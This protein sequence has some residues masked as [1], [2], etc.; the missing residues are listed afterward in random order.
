MPIMRETISDSGEV[1]TLA[2]TV[3]YGCDPTIMGSPVVNLTEGSRATGMNAA[4]LLFNVSI[5]HACACEDA[6]VKCRTGY[7]AHIALEQDR[8]KCDNYEAMEFPVI[9]ITGI[10]IFV[11]VLMAERRVAETY[12]P[13]ILCESLTR[14]PKFLL[15][16]VAF[17]LNILSPVNLMENRR[18]SVV[19]ACIFGTL[20]ALIFTEIVQ[21]NGA[22]FLRATF[23]LFLLYPL[24]LCRSCHDRLS[25]S[26]LGLVYCIVFTF[27]MWLRLS[28]RWKAQQHD[29]ALYVLIPAVCCNVFIGWFGFRGYQEIRLRYFSG[30]NGGMPVGGING[31][32]DDDFEI[33]RPRALTLSDQG[34][35]RQYDHNELVRELLVPKAQQEQSTDHEGSSK[36]IWVQVVGFFLSYGRDFRKKYSYFR[37]S[38]RML[39]MAAMSWCMLFN[40]MVLLGFLMADFVAWG[41]DQLSGGLCC[42]GKR[43]HH[44]DAYLWTKWTENSTLTTLIDASSSKTYLGSSYDDCGTN[45]Q[46]LTACQITLV[47]AGVVMAIAHAASVLNLVAVYRKHMM[48][49][50]RGDI[51]FIS[52][53]VPGPYVALTDC[54]KYVSYQVIFVICGWVFSTVL[55]GAV[56]LLVAFT[57]ILPA[58]GAYRDHFWPWIWNTYCW[59]EE[60]NEMGP[61]MLTIVLYLIMMVMV[62]YCFMDRS[63]PMALTNRT[64]WDTF[65]LFQ[66]I[67]NFLV[68]FFMFLKR[69]VV[70]VL[71]GAIFISRLDKPLVPRGYEFWDPGFACY[72]GFLLTEMFYS[73][74]VM[75]TFVQILADAHIVLNRKCKDDDDI[76]G[77]SPVRGRSPV[78]RNR[79]LS[80]RAERIGRVAPMAVKRWQLVYTLL[81]NPE[82]VADRRQSQPV[83]QVEVTS[84]G[85]QWFKRRV[86]KKIVNVP[87]HVEQHNDRDSI[88]L[89]ADLEPDERYNT[90]GYMDVEPTFQSADDD[91][92][93]ESGPAPPDEGVSR[94]QWESR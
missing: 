15:K 38:P 51:T 79:R 76:L 4:E 67:A 50:Y 63:V 87:V 10:V 85:K 64:L 78:Q 34:L 44:G 88:L 41:E 58:K 39:V 89:D 59:N 86:G 53:F 1:V 66:T 61:L 28:C 84:S 2:T 40:F 94:R 5:L 25:G 21:P 56:F 6:S 11:L 43:C 72:Q 35:H 26:V 3:T 55:V 71:F 65:D 70:Q 46:I 19:V 31:D 92:L 83:E 33:R 81:R 13:L 36:S 77:A 80:K 54:L 60:T 29:L 73:N 42:G 14:H 49:F 16:D 90:D 30:P 12:Q 18:G 9:G 45:Y 27:F 52:K 23:W 47:F 82:L 20:A 91:G 57:V 22:Q 8:A 69:I 37:Y 93:G 24:F 32:G 74:P 62:W 68:G 17:F 75:L 48:R 7:A